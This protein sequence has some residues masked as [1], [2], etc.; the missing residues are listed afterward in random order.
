MRALTVIPGKAHSLEVMDVPDPEPGPDD[1]L[2]EGLAIGICGTDHEI[3]AGDYGWA[4]PGR[5]RLGIGHES[6]G[7][8]RQAPESSGFAVGDL[9]VGVVRRPDPEPCGACA[10][11]QFDMCR[12]G[13]Y[14]ERGIKQIDGYG[15]EKWK[16]EADYAVKLDPALENVGMLLEP[17]SVVAKA[18]DQIGK[19]GGRSWFDPKRV[20]ITGAG[21][22]GPAPVI[23]AR[24]GAK[25]ARRPIRSIWSHAL[26]T[27]VVGSISIPTVSSDGSSLTA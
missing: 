23:S 14:T 27:I 13:K 6:L 15:S 12:N 8:V 9:V 21:P 4:P 2:V 17:T 24:S 7:R 3:A 26:A 16:V 11:G 10:H 18:G 25:Y 5:D 22:I 19:V 1:L 20:L